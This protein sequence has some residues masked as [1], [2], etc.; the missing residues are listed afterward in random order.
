MMQAL[1]ADRFKLK[2]HYEIK[3]VP[4]LALVLD[5]PGKLGPKMQP[6]PSDAACSVA[7]PPGG[8]SSANGGTPVTIA[9]GFPERCGA[10][11]T[12]EVSG[13]FRMGARNVPLATFIKQIVVPGFT[14][15]D[16]PVLDK[17]GLEG[18]YDFVLEFTP[19]FTE[20]LP[21][22]ATFVPDPSGPTF[23]Q[24][25][26]EQLGL[27][28]ESQTGPATVFVVDHIEQPSEN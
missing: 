17:T 22:G 23:Q 10:I 13:R 7:I 28:L 20:P 12:W 5:K 4:T 16:R 27:R 15:I 3:Q 21:P 24:A 19:Q 6:H 1:L 9:G 25:L 11:A 8:A 26:K 2:V 14:G 18:T